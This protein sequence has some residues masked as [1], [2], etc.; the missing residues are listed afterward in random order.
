MKD[1][2]NQ[3]TAV[4]PKRNLVNSMIIGTLGLLSGLYLCFPGAG[5]LR[6]LWELVPIVGQFDEAAA[7]AI[8]FSC[9]AYFGIDLTHMFGKAKEY[10]KR[11]AKAEANKK[12]SEDVIDAKVVE[13]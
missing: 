4:K 9:L 6:D 10:D 8:L 7:A 5:F 1:E 11:A 12:K 13:S 3:S 2:T